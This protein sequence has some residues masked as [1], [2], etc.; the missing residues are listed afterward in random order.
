MRDP[1]TNASSPQKLPT[2]VAEHTIIYVYISPT[3]HVDTAT[4]INH[5]GAGTQHS[6]KQMAFCVFFATIWGQQRGYRGFFWIWVHGL[7]GEELIF[8]FAGRSS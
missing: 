4:S 5:V 7:D 6:E 1:I 8:F 2:T 3:S